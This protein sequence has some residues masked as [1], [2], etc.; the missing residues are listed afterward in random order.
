MCTPARSLRAK[1]NRVALQ[2][3]GSA[4]RRHRAGKG[5]HQPVTGAI[6]DPPVLSRDGN[7]GELAVALEKIGPAFVTEIAGK[8][9][10]PFDVR[11]ENCPNRFARAMNR[12]EAR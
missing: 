8:S 11:L 6:D 2:A 3:L 10:R 12:I 1:I 7:A 4:D 5:G 9:G